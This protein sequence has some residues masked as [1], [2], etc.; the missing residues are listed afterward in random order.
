MFENFYYPDGT[1]PEW[2]AIDCLQ[3]IFMELHRELRLI[4]PLTFPVTTMAMVHDGTD[5]IDKEY[6]KLCA[7]EWA[8]GGSFFCYLSDNPS[9][10]ASCCRVL[11]EIQDNT[12]SSINGL[13]GVMTGSCNVIT[14]NINRI[15]QDFVKCY[16]SW[17]PEQFK[18]WLIG[19]LDR[20]YKYHIAY[21][22]ML[23]EWEDK[24]AFASSNAG[25]IYLK[26]L[27]ST[28][29]I[30]GYCEA[31]QF[32]GLEISNNKEYKEFLQLIFGT[33]KEQ[34]KL[35]SIR[36]AKRPFLFNS[37]AIPGENL[38]VKLYEWDKQDGY[39]VPED[40]N[41]YSSYFFKQWDEK[42]SVL[43][44]LKLHGKDI[45]PYCDGGQACHIHLEEHLSKEQY[46]KILDFCISEG[47]SYFTFNI[48]MSE[49][50]E[51]GHVV[52]APIK[53]CPICHGNNIDYWVRIIGY[54]RPM[55]AFSNPRQI[56]ASKR[57]YN[58]I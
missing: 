48:P 39:F 14:L 18:G 6:K 7:E 20:V 32:L 10:L 37:E 40:Q 22:T 12:F 3:R 30:I 11:N 21:K 55:S 56:E 50:K 1:Q 58:K 44:K 57:I 33:I 25:Y 4:K 51:C 43:D 9:S 17:T 23:Y 35:H 49:C 29:G 41:L 47:V 8:K 53:E 2:E 46:N 27:Y 34:N 28:I 31:A 45:A 36:D 38:A 26:K 42:I 19:I 52:N 54:L 5:V 16:D 13:Q 24:G 15:V